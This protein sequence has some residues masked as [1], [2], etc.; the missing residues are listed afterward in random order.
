MKDPDHDLRKRFS[1]LRQEELALV[2][3][4]RSRCAS[5]HTV[6]AFQGRKP[7][8]PLWRWALPVTAAAVLAIVL[9]RAGSDAR[10]AAHP[11]AGLAGLAHEPM[12]PPPTDGTALFAHIEV[13]SSHLTSDDLMP[14]HLTVSLFD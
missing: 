9:F 12:L 14:F 7:S 4:I 6:P 11:H 10:P 1:E 8:L 2:P 13:P 3:S 5:A